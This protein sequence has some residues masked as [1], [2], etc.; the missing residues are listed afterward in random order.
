MKVDFSD[1]KLIILT[2][3]TTISKIIAAPISSHVEKRNLA[4]NHPSLSKSRLYGLCASPNVERRRYVPVRR[5]IRPYLTK[6][7]C[8]VVSGSTYLMW[9]AAAAQQQARFLSP[10]SSQIGQGSVDNRW[11]SL[12]MRSCFL[13]LNFNGHTSQPR[14][15]GRFDVV[16]CECF[17][18]LEG[19]GTSSIW[20]PFYRWD[21]W[22]DRLEVA[23]SGS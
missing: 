17:D 9:A 18:D 8:G 20:T 2:K 1:R 3:P 10:F 5:Y 23:K 21:T 4:K 16:Q 6:S 22:A 13:V 12:W 15:K 7:E 11:V 14:S 19:H